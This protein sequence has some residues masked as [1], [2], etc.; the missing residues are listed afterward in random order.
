MF[1]N[2]RMSK[3]CNYGNCNNIVIRFIV[4][5]IRFE[6]FKVLKFA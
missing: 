6:K 4:L 2:F 1:D 5:A 3:F